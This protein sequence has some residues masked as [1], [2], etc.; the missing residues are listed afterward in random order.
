MIKKSRREKKSP[1]VLLRLARSKYLPNITRRIN[2]M[3]SDEEIEKLKIRIKK[4]YLSADS[5]N[6]SKEKIKQLKIEAGEI[7]V[8]FNY[9]FSERDSEGYQDI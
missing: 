2:S 9:W 6:K 4:W 3:E 8:D 1:S 5:F 7:I